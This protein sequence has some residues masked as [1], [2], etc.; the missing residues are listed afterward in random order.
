MLNA[1]NQLGRVVYRERIDSSG[2]LKSST[3]QDS[4]S[5]CP[6]ALNKDQVNILKDV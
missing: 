6:V 1:G 2:K 4:D 5:N 3:A